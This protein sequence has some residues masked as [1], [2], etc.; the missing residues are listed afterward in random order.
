MSIQRYHNRPLNR[1]D[2][3]GNMPEC[4]GL[5]LDQNFAECRFQRPNRQ[6]KTGNDVRGSRTPGV[7]PVKIILV[8]QIPELLDQ[9]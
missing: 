8:F 6:N 1:R 7:I 3:A 4:A 2:F 9:G 5:G